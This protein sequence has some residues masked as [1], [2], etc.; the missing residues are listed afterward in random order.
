MEK[1]LVTIDSLS[2]EEIGG[3]WAV[4]KLHGFRIPNNKSDV[5]LPGVY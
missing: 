1:P 2:L 4:R 5:N 3:H